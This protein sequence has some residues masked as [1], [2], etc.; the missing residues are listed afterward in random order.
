MQHLDKEAIFELQKIDCNCN[1]CIF[2]VR[3]AEKFKVSLENHY[4]W[5]FDYFTTIK[6]KLIQKAKWYKDKFYDLEMWDNLL[7]EADRMKFIF[8]KSE[9]KLNFGYCNK[10]N[11]EVSFIPNHCQLDT[12]DCFTHRKTKI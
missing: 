2:M 11:K 5:Q 4:K 9:A 3:D 12:Q 6:N 1:D 7:T 8:N 10:K